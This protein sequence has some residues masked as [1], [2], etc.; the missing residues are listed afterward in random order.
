M[1]MREGDLLFSRFTIAFACCLCASKSPEFPDVASVDATYRAISD[2]AAQHGRVF[3]VHQQ[4]GAEFSRVT[5]S[6]S[7]ARE[8]VHRRGG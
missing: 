4:F 3:V 8:G 7:N 6:A 5:G 2:S 1:L